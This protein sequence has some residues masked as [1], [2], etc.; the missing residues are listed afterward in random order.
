M[1]TDPVPIGDILILRCGLQ[2]IVEDV[3]NLLTKR[4]H[5]RL[6]MRLMDELLERREK[7]GA[8]ER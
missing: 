3:E 1:K 8:D 6:L 5:A 4:K 7:D 2:N